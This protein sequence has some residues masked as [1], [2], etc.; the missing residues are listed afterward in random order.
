MLDYVC[1]QRKLYISFFEAFKEIMEDLNVPFRQENLHFN[2]LQ[3]IWI[4]I[5]N[6]EE[7][8]INFQNMKI[9]LLD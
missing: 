5:R 8:S 2:I 4:I 1:P 7:W 9:H 6:F 3:Y